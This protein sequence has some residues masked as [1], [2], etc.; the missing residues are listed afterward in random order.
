[1]SRLSKYLKQTAVLEKV[2]KDASGLPVMDSYGKYTYE[3][4]VNIK[5]RR[6]PAK[7]NVLSATGQYKNHSDTYYVDESVKIGIHDKLDGNL[8]LSVYDYVD[9]SGQLVGYEVSV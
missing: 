4:P 6:E 5:C 9:G 3:S 1:M 8:V 2:K 7:M